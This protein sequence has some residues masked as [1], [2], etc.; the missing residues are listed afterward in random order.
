VC[1]EIEEVKARPDDFTV[2]GSGN[3]ERVNGMMVSADFFT[4]LGVQPKLGRGVFGR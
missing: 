2:A 3:P 4:T 1:L